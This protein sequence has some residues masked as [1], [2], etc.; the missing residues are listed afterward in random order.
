MKFP[1]SWLK[2][3]VDVRTSPSQI[4]K[5]LTQLGIE[6][7]SLDHAELPFEKVIIGKVIAVEKHPFADKLQIAQV[8]DGVAEFQVVCGAPNCR[9]GLKTAFAV[10][11]SSIKDEKGKPFT[12]KK[13][14]I[15]DIDSFGMLCSAKELQIGHE[16]DGIIEFADHLDEGSDIAELYADTVFEVSLTPNLGHCLSLIGI[17]RE[18]SAAIKSTVKY[19]SIELKD[20]SEESGFKVK[21]EDKPACPRYAFRVIKN[22][23]IG[24]SPEWMQ[25]RLIGC[26]LRPVNNVVDATNYVLME[27]GHPLHAFD[28]DKVE[29]KKIIVRQAAEGEMLTT[30]DGKERHLIPG[31]L[32]ICDEFKPIA[33]AGI[34]GGQNTEVND[35]T[36]NI[37]IESAFFKPSVIRRTSKRLGLQTD[38]SKRFERS[39][40]PEQVLRALDRVAKLIQEISGGE[41]CKVEID[42]KDDGFSQIQVQCRF[43]RINDLL[44]THLS[45][46]EVEDVFQRL[47]FA[48]HWNG[49]DVFTVTVPTYRADIHLEVDIIEEVARFYGYDNIPRV[50]PKYYASSLPNTPIFEFESTVRRYM[51]AEG[52][53]EFVTCDLIGPTL[54]D[55]VQDTSMPEE[56]IIKI[57]NP[58][59]IEQSILR[60]SLLPGLLQ[61]VKFNVDHENRNVHGFEVG[62]I[63]FKQGD[64]YKEQL[65]LGI[66]L[67]GSSAPLSWDQPERS[68]DF[69][70]L[71]GIVENFLGGVRISDIAFKENHLSTL[72][73]GRQSSIYAGSLEIG[74]LGEVH[75][76]I[77]R[78]LDVSQ[79][80]YFAEINI[81]DLIRLLPSDAQ[82]SEL[83]L[84]PASERDWTVTLKEE[85]P[86]EAIFSVLESMNSRLLEHI[87]LIA[88]YRSEKLGSGK[89]NATFHLVYR[90]RKKTISQETVDAEHARILTQITKRL[91]NL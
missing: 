89:K 71:K 66:I 2:E 8:T 54:L 63:H 67:T 5:I 85:T 11:G 34:M 28:L 32:L 18:L 9:A 17:A 62:R 53:Q 41:I 80:I 72:H 39:T 36:H 69:Y 15:R 12:I 14:K 4:A 83:P 35:D 37:L 10:I 23:K 1:L 82:M 30:L 3:Y 88:I 31:D 51:L 24:P 45:V 81:H 56:A 47:D 91:E 87:S 52:L 25:K 19:P 55:V 44:G 79:R 68:F 65:V 90:D 16:S 70:D 48:Y 21:I 50:D 57:V 59:S 26:G 49:H 40:D 43:S 6:V 86:I 64:Q 38:A 20:S 27:L 61:V 77:Q 22:V 60:T 33:L 58:T 74:S 78:R 75:P 42:G 76:A 84:Y 29:G 73:S 46:S 13:S 7:D